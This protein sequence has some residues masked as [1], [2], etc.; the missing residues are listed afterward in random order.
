MGRPAARDRNSPVEQNAQ[1]H[2][3]T[4]EGA[5]IKLCVTKFFSLGEVFP[6]V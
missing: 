3:E 4:H 6:A 2:Q 5:K 1:F